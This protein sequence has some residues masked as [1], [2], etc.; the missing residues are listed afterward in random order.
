MDVNYGWR[1]CQLLCNYRHVVRCGEAGLSG[2]VS[3]K[4][5]RRRSV[6]MNDMLLQK[7][8]E[9]TSQ[10]RLGSYS[11]TGVSTEHIIK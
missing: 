11:I 10:I 4:I 9:L 8:G 5:R 6:E 1:Q 2:G 3:V 7:P